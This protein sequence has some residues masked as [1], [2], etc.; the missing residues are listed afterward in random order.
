MNTLDIRCPA[1]GNP[2]HLSE[3]KPQSHGTISAAFECSNTAC[4]SKFGGVLTL[5]RGLPSGSH[6]F[7]SSAGATSG[8][9]GGDSGKKWIGVDF[10]GTLAVEHGNGRMGDPIPAMVTRV[11]QWLSEGFQVRIFTARA[12]DPDQVMDIRAWLRRHG[13]P[14]MPITNVK[15]PSML[16][17]WDDKAVRVVHNDGKP[18]SGCEPQGKP[19]K[20]SAARDCNQRGEELTDC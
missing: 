12:H 8:F 2:S 5:T 11:R 3:A 10:D 19:G 18:C 1:C 16:Q 20:H 15:E 14:D 4:R 17:L 6:A 9:A 13:L 7:S